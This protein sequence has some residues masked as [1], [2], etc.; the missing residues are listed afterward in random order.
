MVLVLV[1]CAREA[2]LEMLFDIVNPKGFEQEREGA[3]GI[4]RSHPPSNPLTRSLDRYARS[5]PQMVDC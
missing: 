5:D 1:R 3:S 4:G 2:R